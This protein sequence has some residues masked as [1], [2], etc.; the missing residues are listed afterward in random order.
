MRAF[1]EQSIDALQKLVHSKRK[2]IRPEEETRADWSVTRGMI[3]SEDVLTHTRMLP[4]PVSIC[5]P[6]WSFTCYSYHMLSFMAWMLEPFEVI[7][8]W[9]LTILTA[10][11]LFR[12]FFERHSVH[13]YADHVSSR[14]NPGRQSLASQIELAA[15][16]W[17]HE[18]S[19]LLDG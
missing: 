13:K 6:T 15:D 5:I 14:L 12:E 11:L 10:S 4:C 19:W 9:W 3:W 7:H 16:K 8:A 18:A 17:D 1:G 2:R